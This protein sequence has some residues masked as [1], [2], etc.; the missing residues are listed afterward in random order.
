MTT[1][2]KVVSDHHFCRQL[3]SPAEKAQR[4]LDA[5]ERVR[6]RE[7]VDGQVQQRGAAT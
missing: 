7:A 5:A 4:T 6:A 2:T 3:I 1:A